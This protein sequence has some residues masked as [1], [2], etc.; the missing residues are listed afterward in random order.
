MAPGD[1]SRAQN[2]VCASAVGAP[3]SSAACRAARAPAADRGQPPRVSR[4]RPRRSGAETARVLKARGLPTSN[5]ASGGTRP[6]CAPLQSAGGWWV[7]RA[8]TAG[9]NGLRRADG[10]GGLI[11]E[12]AAQ[13]NPC[14]RD[15][16]PSG[17][18][19]WGPHSPAARTTTFSTHAP[20]AFRPPPTPQQPSEAVEQ[21]WFVIVLTSQ[22]LLRTGRRSPSPL[23][24]RVRTRSK[25]RCLF[26]RAQT[27]LAS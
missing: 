5:R 19:S 25:L 14:E 24:P 17:S 9:F 20:P 13:A 1:W 8:L 27:L 15:C 3:G 6:A 2:S 21:L 10:W 12:P 23:P 4:H 26:R 11:M 18:P 22:G 7:D 16:C